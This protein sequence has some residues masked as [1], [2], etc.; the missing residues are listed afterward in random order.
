MKQKKNSNNEQEGYFHDLDSHSAQNMTEE[1][2]E[3]FLDAD[4]NEEYT[5]RDY[6]IGYWDLGMYGERMIRACTEEMAKEEFL[7]GYKSKLGYQPYIARCETLAEVKERIAS[8]GDLMPYNGQ[9]WVEGN[10]RNMYYEA[11]CH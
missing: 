7:D 8:V 4:T 6:K 10:P 2:W 9:T 3:N 11:M 1:D 5:E